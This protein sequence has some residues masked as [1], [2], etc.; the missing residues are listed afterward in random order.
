MNDDQEILVKMARDYLF[1]AQY[2]KNVKECIDK[3]IAI[4]TKVSQSLK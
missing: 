2:Q 1:K 4:L 3:A